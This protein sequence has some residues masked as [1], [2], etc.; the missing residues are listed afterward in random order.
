MRVEIA[1]SESQ[2][3]EVFQIRKTV[4]VNEQHVPLA[5][6]ID[7]FE[8]GSTHFV[9]YDGDLAAGAGRFR[10]VDGGIGKIERICVLKNLRSKGAGREI[11]LAMEQYA[12]DK[13]IPKLKLNAQTYAIPFYE[14]LGFEIVSEE[15]MDAGI[16]HKTMVK[17]II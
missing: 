14:G 5:E 6:E 3:E 15:F 4:F 13:S 16:P 9:L 12:K 17:T 1:N 10:I 2:L 11:M 7:E 8:N